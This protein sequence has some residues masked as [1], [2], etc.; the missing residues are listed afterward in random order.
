MRRFQPAWNQER[1]KGEQVMGMNVFENH[2]IENIIKR[3]TAELSQMSFVEGIVLGGSR[4]SGTA[5]ETSDIDIGI[6]YNPETVDYDLMNAAA[7]RLDDDNRA[8]LICRAGGWG[9]W[10]NC[11]GWL[12]IDGMPVDLIMRDMERVKNEVRESGEGRISSHYQ[13]GHPHAYLNV[14]YRGELAISRVLYAGNEEFTRWKEE[15]EQYPDKMREAILSFFLFEAQFSCG[16]AETSAKKQDA[17]YTAGHL[18]RSVSALN[19]VLFALNRKYCLNEKKAVMRIEG[20][21]Q[22]PEGYGEKVN[23]IF[24]APGERAEESAGLLRKLCNEVSCLCEQ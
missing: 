11:G 7:A 22:R 10:V 8:D 9:Q 20:F 14:M 12:K 16:F 24:A 17:Y 21:E 19:Q 23:R 2:V 18:F 13:T 15:A 5:A 4:A 1:M 3:V 6:Y